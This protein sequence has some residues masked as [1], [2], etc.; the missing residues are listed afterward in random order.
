MIHLIVGASGA[1]GIPTLKHLVA[2][3]ATVRALSSNEQSAE[4]LKALGASEVIVGDY[5]KD[6]DVAKAMDGVFA[7]LFVPPRFT[8]D[9]AEIGFRVID[10]A[11]KADVAT[12]TFSSAYHPQMRSLDHHWTKLLIEEALIKSDLP[13]TIVQPSMF[14]QNLRVEWPRLIETGKY[15]RPYSPFKKMSVLDTDDLGEALA[16]IMTEIG[17]EGATFEIC[18]VDRLS[19]AEMAMV[20]SDVLGRE[21]VAEQRDLEEWETWAKAQ[22]WPD[23]SREAYKKMCAHYDAHGYPGGNP[24]VARTILGRDPRSFRD[25]VTDFIAEM[26]AA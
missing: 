9:E 16:V 22:G 18:G 1:V 21:I 8:E 10:A 19:T 15:L 11:K 12:F 24:L 25:F 17:Y 23:W 3:G 4:R 13:Y 26:E 6:E 14:M 2:R 7:V 5:R 20:I